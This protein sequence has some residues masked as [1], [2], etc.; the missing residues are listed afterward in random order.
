MIKEQFYGQ[1]I[2][3]LI[4]FFNL[5]INGVVHVGAHKCE[6]LKIYTDYVDQDKTLWIEANPSL[7]DES[8]KSYPGL[9]IFNEV[10]GEV[11]GEVINFNITNNTLSSSTLDFKEHSK[12]HPHVKV[13]DKFE[14]KTKTLNTI[15]KE[16]NLN[17]S[18]YNFLVLDIQ[19]VELSAIK[20]LQDNLSHFDII[21]TEV[22]EDEL[23]EG[24]CR[25]NELDSYLTSFNFK[26]R[27][28][29]TLNGYGN[30]LY[31]KPQTN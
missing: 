13:V 30:A 9:K 26:R 4:E 10:V 3:E 6:E 11:D 8:L 17:F 25:L 22:N 27:F 1:T 24:C 31:I 23:Y 2:K 29:T 12:L 20:G 5:D 16:N 14:A 15:F 19:G 7:I 18:D 21:F 28:T